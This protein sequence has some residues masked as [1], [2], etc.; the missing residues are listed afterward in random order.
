[1]SD[2]N[3]K[4]ATDSVI[5]AKI[6]DIQVIND[7]KY[8]D[9]QPH[10]DWIEVPEPANNEGY[11]LMSSIY[12][13]TPSIGLIATTST[14][15]YKVDWGDGSAVEYFNSNVQA[16][17]TYTSGGKDCSLGYK[18]WLIKVSAVSGNIASFSLAKPYYQINLTSGVLAININF[19]YATIFNSMLGYN[20]VS[21]LFVQ[22]I[23]FGENLYNNCSF[24]STFYLAYNLE[25]V[26]LPKNIYGNITSLSNI[27]YSC[28]KLKEVENLQTIISKLVGTIGWGFVECTLDKKYSLVLPP[29]ITELA[30]SF[31]KL[32]A[33]QS[34]IEI[35]GATGTPSLHSCFN[36]AYIRKVKFTGQINA[37]NITY[38]FQNAS[39]LESLEGTEYIGSQTSNVDGTNFFVNCYNLSSSYTLCKTN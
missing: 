36:T 11:I 22:Y 13:T 9:W 27:F 5:N 20:D 34:E 18:T 17:H 32:V 24:Y 31:N 10:P 33:P 30:N 25:K 28:R 2:I 6:A 39:I 4:I 16:D 12:E 8:Y 29:T 35:K 23:K 3:V 7:T 21:S 19:P 14:G 1:M 37:T 15:Q 38:A 26:I